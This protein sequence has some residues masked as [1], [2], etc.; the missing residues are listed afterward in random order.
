MSCLSCFQTPCCCPQEQT[1]PETL[2]YTAENANLA[3]VGVFGAQEGLVFRFRGVAAGDAYIHVEYNNVQKV[4]EI[5][6]NEALLKMQQT[7]V[8]NAQRAS[9]T[10]AFLGQLL[11]QINTQ[12]I[13]IGTSLVAGGWTVFTP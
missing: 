9:L 7:A 5:S 13:Y 12:K 10:P 1:C 4:I 2:E 3:G 6:L 8:D 11:V